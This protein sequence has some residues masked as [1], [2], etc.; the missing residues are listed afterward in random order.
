MLGAVREAGE[1]ERG[2]AGVAAEPGERR[3]VVRLRLAPAFLLG[4]APILYRLP[5]YREPIH[6]TGAISW[7]GRDRAAL[8]DLVIWSSRPWPSSAGWVG[9]PFLLTVSVCTADRQQ[10]SRES[11]VSLEQ[12]VRL[13]GDIRV[14]FPM[15][16]SPLP[17]R[18]A[19]RGRPAGP[20]LRDTRHVRPDAVCALTPVGDAGS[21]RQAQT[22]IR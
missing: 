1:D 4:T 9:Q 13:V 15:P 19:L 3:R 12:T 18:E 2:R 22:R 14:C 21:C 10:L 5:I 8:P 11:T 16:G 6:E 20:G 7:L 17:C